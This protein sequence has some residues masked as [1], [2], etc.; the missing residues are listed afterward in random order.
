M[1][2]RQGKNLREFARNA[3]NTSMDKQINSAEITFMKLYSACVKVRVNFIPMQSIRKVPK[4]PFPIQTFSHREL[5]RK[6]R[7]VELQ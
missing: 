1:P 6:M 3:P 4:N 2:H 5:R 7:I